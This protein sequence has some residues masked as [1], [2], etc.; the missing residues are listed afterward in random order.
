MLAQYHGDKLGP[1]R[2]ASRS[3][4]PTESHWSTAHQES[5]AVKLALKHFCPYLMGRKFTIITYHA[6]L[7]FLSS[8]APQNSKLAHWCLS[9]DEFDIVIEHCPGNTNIV[10]HDLGCAPLPFSIE[11]DMLFIHPSET[12]DFFIQ[13]FALD[14]PSITATHNDPLHCLHLT[15]N[16]NYLS[17]KATNRAEV[18]THCHRVKSNSCACI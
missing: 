18:E 9:L 3:F 11:V 6:H 13:T 5:F 2:F 8:I 17:N 7:K 12:V 10:P 15:C 16:V 4:S 14:I 1:V